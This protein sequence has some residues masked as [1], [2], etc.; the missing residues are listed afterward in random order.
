MEWKYQKEWVAAERYVWRAPSSDQQ[1]GVASGYYKGYANLGYLKVLDAGHFVP[2]DVPYTALDMF[3]TFLQDTVEGEG[4]SFAMFHQK[5]PQ[6]STDLFGNWCSS[7]NEQEEGQDDEEESLSTT[8]VPTTLSSEDSTNNHN[9]WY[10]VQS[11]GFLLG[12]VFTLVNCI[13]C[14]LTY[15]QTN[16]YQLNRTLSSTT[17]QYHPIENKLS[18]S[19]DDDDDDNN[20]E[21]PSRYV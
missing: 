20:D 17:T 6:L 7:K 18:S 11:G 13:I 12:M 5:I 1:L 8:Q 10:D 2:M 9:A 16:K 15:R 21:E 14:L 19:N 4:S 3:R